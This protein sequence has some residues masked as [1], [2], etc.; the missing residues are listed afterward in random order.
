MKNLGGSNEGNVKTKVLGFYPVGTMIFRVMS[1][2]CLV[3]MCAW[4]KGF[5]GFRAGGGV[6]GY[7]DGLCSG[8]YRE[9]NKKGGCDVS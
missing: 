3:V 8:C 4:C 2:K 6:V 9:I 7:S 5:I 1:K